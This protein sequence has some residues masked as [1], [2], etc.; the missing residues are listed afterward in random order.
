MERGKH[1]VFEGGEVAGKSTQARRLAARLHDEGE[2]A[3]VV[4]EPGSTAMGAGIRELLL[5]NIQRNPRTNIYLF[6]AD[7]VDLA[8]TLVKPH[9]SAGHWVVQ[10]RS[11]WSSMAYQA[12]GEGVSS[13]EVKAV[14]QLAIGGLIEP[15]I[16]FFLDIDQEETAR[17]FTKR[18]GKD[19]FEQKGADFHER[20]RESYLAMCKEL[21]GVAI[22]GMG[23]EQ[24]VAR[25]VWAEVYEL[26]SEEV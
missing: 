13:E 6:A 23:S 18:E 10:D 12:G 7:R 22:S 26:F 11:W 4:K 2:T 8:E 21:G 16:V 5:G 17:R 25:D 15:D 3:V 14:N 9:L 24:E 1:I 20:V 19:Y